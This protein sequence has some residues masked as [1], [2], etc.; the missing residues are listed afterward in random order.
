MDCYF[1]FKKKK[2]KYFF[3]C[4]YRNENNLPLSILIFL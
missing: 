4:S 2:K 1:K 3:F